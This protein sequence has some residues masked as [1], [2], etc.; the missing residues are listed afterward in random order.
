M[1]T[2][3]LFAA[4]RGFACLPLPLVHGLGAL[5]GWLAWALPTEARRVTRINLERCLPELS[6]EARRGLARRSLQEAGKTFAELGPMWRWRPERLE[7]L[8]REVDNEGVIADALQSGRGVIALIPHLGCWEICNLYYA[9]RVPLT[10]LYRPPR[11]RQLDAPVQRWRARAGARLAATS[12][13]GVKTLL[14][15]LAAGEVV[16]ILPDQDPGRG[17]GVFAPFFGH[18]AH[19]MTLVSRLVQRSGAQVVTVYGQR[20]PRGRGYRIRLHAVDDA[21]RSPDMAT[22]VAALNRAIERCVR[23]CPEQYQWSYKRFKTTPG[24]VRSPYRR[25]Q[26]PSK[27]H[28]AAAESAEAPAAHDSAHDQKQ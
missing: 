8:V 13:S 16:G 26:A 5:L 2:A 22:S 9:R 1:K 28:A 24:G 14:R 20:L 7:P 4:L 17:A 6:A 18:P 10:V 21:V 11:M 15:A 27:R 19:T 25:R 23:E 12:R 3:L